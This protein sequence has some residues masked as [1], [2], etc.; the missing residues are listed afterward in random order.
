MICWLIYVREDAHRN[1]AYIDWF[2]DEAARQDIHLQLIYRDL[3]TVGIINNEKQIF[4][5]G[6]QMPIP[7]FAVVRVMEP[8]LSKHLHG[9]GI[10]VFNNQWL[11]LTANDKLRTHDFMNSLH[12]PM[13]DTIYLNVSA[14]PA[15]APFSYP[16][17]L[18]D[19]RSRSGKHVFLIHD[20]T[21][22]IQKKEE[23]QGS[24]LLVQRCNVLHGIDI[25]VFI[26]GKEI[27]GA[28]KR[29]NKN[30]FRANYTLGGTVTWYDLKTAERKIVERIVE[31]CEFGMVGIDFLINEKGEFRFNE[32]EDIVG[33][34]SLSKV[35]DIN[36]LRKYVTYIK[37][38]I[39]TQNQ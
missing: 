36:I 8:M 7:T 30:D 32:M 39:T 35:S 28:V 6:K 9:C 5:S 11:S 31:H 10:H 19:A 18:K 20:Q 22:W 13:V 12:I 4:Y 38:K 26:V 23:L 34:R 2:I 17:I 16:V 14:Y 3:L 37:Q 25:R 1:R 27:V 33:S 24:D 21:E 15:E 29:E